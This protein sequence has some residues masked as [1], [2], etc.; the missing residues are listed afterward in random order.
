MFFIIGLCFTSK[1]SAAWNEYGIWFG[2]VGRI[3][4]NGNLWISSE[5]VATYKKNG[6]YNEEDGTENGL[7]DWRIGAS[8]EANR[9]DKILNHRLDGNTIEVNPQPINM[10]I[11]KNPKGIADNRLKLESGISYFSIDSAIPPDNSEMKYNYKNGLGVVVDCGETLFKTLI[12]AIQA[13]NY[14][15][16]QGFLSWQY[17]YTTS[18]RTDFQTAYNINQTN[19]G[20]DR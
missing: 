8:D 17:G 3:Q 5:H 20:D 1:V 15:I 2:S 18:Q 4:Y 10:N 16:L 14:R 19:L 6:K 12:D 13:G 11:F 7:W 9:V